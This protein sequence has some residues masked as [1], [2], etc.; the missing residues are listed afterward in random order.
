MLILYAG[1]LC[2]V[3]FLMRMTGEPPST[4]VNPRLKENATTGSMALYIGWISLVFAAVLAWYGNHASNLRTETMQ[5]SSGIFS[6]DLISFCV[7]ALTVISAFF[8]YYAA[9][10]QRTY[11]PAAL[12]TCVLALI[13]AASLDKLILS[14]T[15]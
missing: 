1:I 6:L 9:R 5:R 13:F 11:G 12:Y 8:A 14:F 2:M 7:A 10:P 4:S 3:L 15:K